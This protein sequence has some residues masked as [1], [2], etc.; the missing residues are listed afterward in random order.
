MQL[1]IDKTITTNS[2]AESERI[3]SMIGRKLRGGEV[4]ELI[5]DLGG[6]K[7]TFVRG[8][9]KGFGSQDK[10]SSPSFTISKVYKKKSFS[11]YHYDFYRLNEVGLMKYELA[12]ILSD[13]KN[14]LVVEWPEIIKDILPKQRL[15]INIKVLSSE[16]RL[17]II[18]S[19]EHLNYL[20]EDL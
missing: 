11:L 16:S 17:F 2:P 6:G 13:P 4:I 15:S 5:S 12:E 14:I 1:I 3:A 19:T 10:V 20:I 8:L 9:N 18:S 7:T